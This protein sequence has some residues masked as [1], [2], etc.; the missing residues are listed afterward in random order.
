MFIEHLFVSVTVLGFKD[1]NE[2]KR[3]LP[4]LS[5]QGGK[6]QGD[7]KVLRTVIRDVSGIRN[8]SC[9]HFMPILK[10]QRTT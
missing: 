7:Y 5:S 8:G 6:G 3:L 10:S 9:I 2:S 4:S 1:T